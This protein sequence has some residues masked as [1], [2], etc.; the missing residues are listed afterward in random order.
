MK[1]SRLF[2]VLR[3]TAGCG[4]DQERSPQT[5]SVPSV[6]AP[7]IRGTLGEIVA[8]DAVS[9]EGE[10]AAQPAKPITVPPGQAVSTVSNAHP[11][12]LEPYG[13]PQG[14]RVDGRTDLYALGVILYRM[15]TGRLPFGAT[16]F[17]VVAGD[18]II[19]AWL[20]R[21]QDAEHF[22]RASRAR[23]GHSGRKELMM[24]KLVCTNPR[25]REEMAVDGG[26]TGSTKGCPKCGASMVGA[27]P[28]TDCEDD[29]VTIDARPVLDA[30]QDVGTIDAR[31]VPG[32][33]RDARPVIARP[34]RVP[35]P[36]AGTATMDARP[37]VARPVIKRPGKATG[38]P[39][40]E[41]ATLDARPIPDGE[42]AVPTMDARPASQGSE[43]RDSSGTGDAEE[44]APTIDA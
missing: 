33:G 16:K 36:E 6:G 22:S 15:L 21:L 2:C 1:A 28:A 39:E 26:R 19:P 41:E 7:A 20:L 3:S 14:H 4:R 11:D 27:G 43:N 44:D 10:T 13:G 32:P 24:H 37:V 12:R 17:T 30:E 35:D 38:D 18:G 42:Q 23:A 40:R 8:A 29:A 31:P 9:S 25:C 34:A 5:L